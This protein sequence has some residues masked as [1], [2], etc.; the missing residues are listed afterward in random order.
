MGK[1]RFKHLVGE[2]I[3]LLGG[4]GQ[5]DEE[6]IYVSTKGNDQYG[7]GIITPYLTFTKAFSAVTNARKIIRGY[8]GTYV[9]EATLDWPDIDDVVLEGMGARNDMV[10]I[11]GATGED[12]IDI[13]PST[14]TST[15]DATI[16]GLTIDGDGDC[17]GLRI[18]NGDVGANIKLI[19]FLNDVN[20]S[21]NED[22]YEAI[23]CVHTDNTTEALRIYHHGPNEFEGLMVIEPEYA[24]DRYYFHGA[25][26]P[27]GFKIGNSAVAA[28]FEF[29]DCIFADDSASG[30]EG[31]STQ[32]AVMIGCASETGGSYAAADKE[33]LG[34]NITVTVI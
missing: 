13:D 6:V 26:F 28:R 29:R 10:T 4:I 25:K 15:F 32:T 31:E 30:D 18:D 5:I 17:T 8:P 2:K 1:E 21:M 14:K 34:T 27:T 3:T 11:I 7:G 9:E 19:V 16:A 24:G 20:I 23:E 12:V 33:D 22:T